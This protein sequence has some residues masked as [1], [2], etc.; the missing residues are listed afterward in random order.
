MKVFKIHNHLCCPVNAYLYIYTPSLK[1]NE[2]VCNLF[3]P[4]AE[5]YDIMD[6]YSKKLDKGFQALRKI[7]TLLLQKEKFALGLHI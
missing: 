2:E 5:F 3:V 7:S 6:A 4:Q 1:C